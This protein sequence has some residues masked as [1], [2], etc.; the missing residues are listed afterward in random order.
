M[1]HF[2]I[3]NLRQ[4]A[5]YW[6]NPAPDGWGGL[7]FDA[8]VEVDCRW[9]E[10]VEVFTTAAGKEARSIAVVFLGQD[11]DV[12]GYLYLGSSTEASPKDVGGAYQIRAFKKVPNIRATY[13][14][15]KAWL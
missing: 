7:T 13:W 9:E 8:P 3:R 1:T 4:T 6:G 14:E 11:V 12:D 15:R 5:T 2:L 10:K